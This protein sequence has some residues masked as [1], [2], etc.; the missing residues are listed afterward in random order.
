[1]DEDKAFESDFQIFP[2]QDFQ[3]SPSL[4]LE[5]GPGRGDFL[6]Y[7]ATE[8]PTEQIVAV[9]YKRKRFEKL[10]ERVGKRELKNVSLVLANARGAIPELFREGQIGKLFILY[11]DPWPKRRHGKNRLLQTE[12]LKMVCEKL[13]KGGLLHIETDDAPYAAEIESS[14]K[15]ITSLRPSQVTATRTIRTLYE[16]KMR[17]KRIFTFVY[18][19]C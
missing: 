16:E 4:M 13:Q 14:L 18:E 10:I 17:G 9:E 12:F 15:E 7:L 6:F 3:I 8:N 19:K 2:N 11:P 5:I 1:M